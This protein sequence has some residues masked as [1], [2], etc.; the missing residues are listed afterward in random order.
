MLSYRCSSVLF[1]GLVSESSS[2]V[3]QE[4]EDARPRESYVLFDR[5][6]RWRFP[7]PLFQPSH[8][9]RSRS[10]DS[11]PSSGRCCRRRCRRQ[12]SLH[13]AAASGGRRPPTLTRPRGSDWTEKT[14]PAIRRK[15]D[16][17]LRCISLSIRILSPPPTDQPIVSLLLLLLPHHFFPQRFLCPGVRRAADGRPCRVTTPAVTGALA[18]SLS[19]AAASEAGWRAGS[20]G[21]VVVAGIRGGG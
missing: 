9:H 7:D 17:V 16:I 4:R 2:E 11:R 6:Y 14:I 3:A 13:A 1:L 12:P 21:V 20:N 18:P 5:F 10:S 8:Q 19:A 15:Q